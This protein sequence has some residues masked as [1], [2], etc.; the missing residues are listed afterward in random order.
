MSI[1]I[2]SRIEIQSAYWWT[3]FYN[4]NH[5]STLVNRTSGSQWGEGMSPEIF[6]QLIVLEKWNKLTAEKPFCIP[7]CSYFSIETCNVPYQSVRH[8]TMQVKSLR[9]FDDLSLV[10]LR[11]GSHGLELI[12]P[13]IESSF[14]KDIWLIIGNASDCPDPD[15]KMIWTCHPGQPF[16]SIKTAIA[17]LESEQKE[18]TVANLHELATRN[19]LDLA[20]KKA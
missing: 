8:S 16:L 10:S 12:S 11:N 19:N 20:V 14:A 6:Q 18:I 17:T 5:L 15:Q 4:R 7:K 13:N 9:E 3:K 1:E 2:Q